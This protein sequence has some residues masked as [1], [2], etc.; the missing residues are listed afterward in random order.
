MDNKLVGRV[1]KAPDVEDVRYQKTHQAKNKPVRRKHQ[2]YVTG[3]RK[4]KPRD[5]QVAITVA[6][7]GSDQRD[8]YYEDHRQRLKDV[9]D[10]P[11]A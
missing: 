1:L 8:P 7:T 4:T 11:R 6:L 9:D 10:C 2:E 5:N 3:Q